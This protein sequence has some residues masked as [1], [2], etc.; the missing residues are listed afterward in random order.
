M[1]QVKKF[2]CLSFTFLPNNF[3]KFW[4][5]LLIQSLDQKI[6]LPLI[7]FLSELWRFWF[8]TLILSFCCH[9]EI[10]VILL[11]S[12]HFRVLHF[13]PVKIDFKINGV[14]L[15]NCSD[16]LWKKIVLVIE[17]NFWNSRLQAEAGGCTRIGS[18]A[19]GI[20][21]RWLMVCNTLQNFWDH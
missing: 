19:I 14:L 7:L 4:A 11:L 16:L 3:A 6:S 21:V 8:C 20:V 2:V 12:N 5:S 13:E 9:P 1:I 10:V 17:K 15:T 18:E